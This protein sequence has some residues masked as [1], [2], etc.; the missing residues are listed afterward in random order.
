MQLDLKNII[1]NYVGNEHASTSLVRSFNKTNSGAWILRGPKGIGKAKLAKN[2][3]KELFNIQRTDNNLLHPDLYILEK[4]EGEKKFIAVENVRNIGSFLSKTSFTGSFRSVIIDSISDMNHFGHNSLLKI[5]EEYQ[6]DTSF[7]IIDH[8]NA[9]IPNTIESR[10]KKIMFKS[11]NQ[12]DIKKLLKKTTIEE[13]FYDNY[14]ALASGSIGNLYN[15]HKYNALDIHNN[16]CNFLLKKNSSQYNTDIIKKLFQN[17]KNSSNVFLISH[18]ILFRLLKNILKVINNLKIDYLNNLEKEVI[19]AFSKKI[20]NE[21]VINL[22]NALYER[23]KNMMN[24]NLDAFT[25]IHLTLLDIENSI[26][27][28]GK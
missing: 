4:K 6:P 10:C 27:K 28:N 16:L 26:V 23:K 18:S 8:M 2:I 24:L 1:S 22:I 11:L 19:D 5:L 12:N 20:D 21:K 25:S 9:Y 13:R 7:F 17:K 14:I 15:L 3:V